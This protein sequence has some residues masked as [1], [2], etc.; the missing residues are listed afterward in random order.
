MT[1]QKDE[2]PR[3]QKWLQGS[4]L[5]VFATT[6]TL[7]LTI[8]FSFNLVTATEVQVTLGE[9]ANDDILA[10]RSIKY[11]SQVLLAAARENAR[12][13]VQEVYTREGNDIG[14]NQLDLVSAV[15]SFTDVVRADALATKETKLLYL[16][17]IN[18]LT[19]QEQVGLNLLEL[20]ASDYEVVK[21]EISRIVGDLMRQDI[22]ECPARGKPGT[23]PSA[24]NCSDQYCTTVYCPHRF[25][26]SRGN[27]RFAGCGRRKCG[28][29]VPRYYCQQ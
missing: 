15:L 17:A 5:W 14:R 10:P 19:V 20:S 22:R 28:Y 29:I 23:D 12:A 2:R 9:P 27:G 7:G 3:W 13:A 6:V 24:G 1:A 4:L 16:Q 25:P 26:R 11:E 8:I 18:S 21:R